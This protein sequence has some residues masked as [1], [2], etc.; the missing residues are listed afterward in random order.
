MSAALLLG[1]CLSAPAATAQPVPGRQALQNADLHLPFVANRGRAGDAAVAFTADT[2]ACRVAVTRS[3]E[4]IYSLPADKNN[5]RPALELKERLLGATAKVRGLDRQPGTVNYFPGRDASQWRRRLPAYGRVGLGQTDAGIRVELAAHSRNVEKFFYIPPG[6]D[7]AAIRMSVQGADHLNV[8]ADGSL[9]LGTPA[10]A[11]RFTKP[12]AF[13][14]ID[15]RRREV[16]VRYRVSGSTYG[17]EPGPYDTSRELVIDP[18]ISVLPIAPGDKL[19]QHD[20]IMD[21]AT[22]AQ[23]NIYAAGY[24]H[25]R[26]MIFK[27]DARLEN[28]LATAAFSKDARYWVDIIR[29]IA[30][31]SQG[32]VFV[33]GTT[34][35]SG[36]PVTP[37][38]HDSRSGPGLVER[39][40][41]VTKF[42]ADLGTILASTYIGGDSDEDIYALAINRQ[43]QIYV[44]GYSKP[45]DTDVQHFP[46]TA[47]AFDTQPAPSHQKK[48]V[49]ARLDNDLAEVQAA[50]F[51]G[52]SV[53]DSLD[54][55]EDVAHCL[56]IDSQGNVW[57]AGRTNQ[58]DFPVTAG[59]LD[60][61]YNGEGDVFLSKLDPDLTQLLVS[62][63][64]GGSQN[65]APT[66]MLLDGQDNLYLL[67]WTFSGDF[68]IPAGGYDT[69]YGNAA[70]D[71]FVL[72]L[73]PAADQILAGTFLGGTFDGRHPEFGDDIPSA[74]AL[75]GDGSQ[76]LVVGRTESTNFPTTPGCRDA[77][78]DYTDAANDGNQDTVA[79]S[80]GP[81][82]DTTGDTDWGDGFI[83]ALSGDLTRLIY[84]T[85]IGGWGC[86]YLD[87]VL[88]NGDDIIVAGESQSAST[89]PL[90]KDPD[91]GNPL[92]SHFSDGVLLRFN[93]N[94]T[95][96]DPNAVP[97]PSSGSASGGGGGGGC[98]ISNC[99]R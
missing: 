17:F 42:S 65:E 73:N 25:G 81:S 67:G 20:A 92:T 89:F 38:C 74:M 53:D 78:L 11:I 97:D 79:A 99:R 88:I 15:G 71:G 94:E 98:F 41:F 85:Y 4:V 37:G 46:V 24:A 21:A 86:D 29:C 3:G 58:P 82:R 34:Y 32:N 18:L 55:N 7:P 70:E 50:T 10:G 54:K 9:E 57:V 83:A 52:G 77:T 51:L 27:V 1:P 90:I 60:P 22:D 61:S 5:R 12:V 6:A 39:E 47:G 66:D 93:E 45:G 28:V 30:I 95:P 49:V 44:A 23:G 68:P 80:A 26:L 69:S 43:G 31:D 91:P 33:A 62:T 16:A 96:N 75:S 40:G 64:I 87:A 14:E 13:Q 59:G 56:A 8:G 48:A 76:L 2:F 36:F 63:H 35:N 84:S 19:D 72:A